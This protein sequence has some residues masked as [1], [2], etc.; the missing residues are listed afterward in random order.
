M[1]NLSPITLDKVLILV[2]DSTTT[3]GLLTGTPSFKRLSGKRFRR[4]GDFGLLA[5]HQS[6]PTGI[7]TRQKG[8]TGQK[9]D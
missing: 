1:L 9:S 4:H 2:G 6:Q 8:K 5:T 3:S 7:L